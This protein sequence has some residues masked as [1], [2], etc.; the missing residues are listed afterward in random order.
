MPTAAAPIRLSKASAAGD[1]APRPN[2]KP[3]VS[4]H[5]GVQG[6]DSHLWEPV[7]DPSLVQLFTPAELAYV[8][9]ELPGQ[10]SVVFA[11]TS[12][13]GEE[14]FP[15]ALRV[16]VLVGLAAPRGKA[17]DEESGEYCLGSLVVVYR[18]RLEEEG[19]VTPINLTQVR[20]HCVSLS[21]V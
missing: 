1:F 17:V 20:I 4:L 16:E 5:G 14:G 19:K 8:Q 2:E 15:G 6:F 7:L 9:S 18:A 3:T 10:A 11:R 21:L 13:D 12:T